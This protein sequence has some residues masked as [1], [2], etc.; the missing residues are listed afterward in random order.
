MVLSKL[1]IKRLAND[2]KYVKKNNLDNE[3][4]YYKHDEENIN[5]GYAMIIGNKESPYKYGYYFFEFNFSDDYP[6][7][8]PVV[9]F[10][11]SD[12]NTRFHPNYYVNGKVCLSLLNTWSGDS[13]TSCCN[14]NTILLVLGSLLIND[15]LLN[16]PG[17]KICDENVKK[18]DLIIGY[19]NIEFSIITQYTRLYNL[20][21]LNYHS[22]TDYDNVMYLFK[23]K[24]YE[25]IK[26]NYDKILEYVNF[27]KLLYE[28][29]YH[30]APARWER[31]GWV[32]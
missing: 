24:I 27:L 30:R 3:N 5:I 13:W 4:I 11:T 19:K 21:K 12:G 18:Y 22:T 14:I 16:E 6:F 29:D 26:I 32:I 8:P 31:Q 28:N 20:D 23:E 1:G 9:K 15:S 10:L 17:I 2:V 25:N 7:A